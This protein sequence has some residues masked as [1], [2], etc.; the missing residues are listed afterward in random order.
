MIRN[1]AE[2]TD[3][4]VVAAKFKPRE[5]G[6]L[7]VV[8]IS[9][10]HEKE[11]SLAVEDVPEGDILIHAGDITYKGKPA[12]FARFREWMGRLPHKHKIVIAGNHDTTL[13]DSFK[14]NSNE[15]DVKLSKKEV[16][17]VDEFQYLQ[18][19]TIEI[20]GY[21]FYGSPMQPVISTWAFQ[22]VGIGSQCFSLSVGS[23]VAEGTGQASSRALAA[24]PT[25]Y[26]DFGYTW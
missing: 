1:K 25:R 9:D 7:R 18:E 3:I 13:D 23:D 4:E 10:T 2:S 17:D 16:V 14:F 12:A 24:N 22:K 8:T 21:K 6:M 20:E 15:E 5:E 26:R 19:D 11:G